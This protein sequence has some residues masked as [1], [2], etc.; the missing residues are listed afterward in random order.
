M[1]M[2]QTLALDATPVALVVLDDWRSFSPFLISGE[3][4][5]WKKKLD[6]S[7]FL[8]WQRQQWDEWLILEV[9]GFIGAV[10]EGRDTLCFWKGF[11]RQSGHLQLAPWLIDRE[12][13]IYLVWKQFIQLR[14]LNAHG[15]CISKCTWFSETLEHLQQFVIFY[16]VYFMFCQLL[17]RYA[18]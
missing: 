6:C 17:K 10:M 4:L 11:L 3:V 9:Y 7:S 5:S 2:R 15:S 1:G 8:V 16:L 14:S 12:I 18:K 13:L